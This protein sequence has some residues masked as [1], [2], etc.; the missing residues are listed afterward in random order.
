MLLARFTVGPFAENPYVVG[1]PPAVAIVDPGGGSDEIARHLDERGWRPEAILLT[2][3]HLDHI[4]HCAHLAERYGIG[5]TVHRDDLFLLRERQMPELW[6]LLGARP[7]PE[8]ER[9]WEDGE[10]VAVAGVELQV[11]HTPGHTP[12][13]VCLL[14]GESRSAL[15]GDTIFH[16]GIGRT[17]LPGGDFAAL[18][19]SIHER[20]F[21]LDG[22]WTLHP[23]HGPATALAE[24]RTA[25]PFFGAASRR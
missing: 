1:V 9:F 15:V 10:T 19:R 22:D 5:I 14:H 2:H 8:P 20:L 16:R 25:N 4:A 13:G 17:D 3:G 11:L 24:E 12:G 6:P 21:A 7:C 23:G 18:E